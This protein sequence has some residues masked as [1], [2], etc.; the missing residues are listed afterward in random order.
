[1]HATRH[2]PPSTSSSSKMQSSSNEWSPLAADQQVNQ[3]G[4]LNS[5][6]SGLMAH[7]RGSHATPGEK[8]CCMSRITFY[9]FLATAVVLAICIPLIIV[10]TRPSD[11]GNAAAA[12]WPSVTQISTRDALASGIYDGNTT[13][14][15]VRSYGS[16]GLGT[17]NGLDGKQTLINSTPP[18]VDISNQ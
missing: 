8:Q 5:S 14:K 6:H 7:G 13:L 10:R 18:L 16:F 17:Y 12:A 2:R 4:G 1:M 3:R 9:I 11:G 15:Q